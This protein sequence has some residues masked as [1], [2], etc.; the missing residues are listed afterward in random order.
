MYPQG[1]SPVGALDMSGNVWEWCLNE[2][3]NPQ[4]V[5]VRGRKQRTLRGGSWGGEHTNARCA[6]R[7]KHLPFTRNQYISFRLYCATFTP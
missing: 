4:Q 1:E 6:Y 5:E 7:Y 2:H 3:D